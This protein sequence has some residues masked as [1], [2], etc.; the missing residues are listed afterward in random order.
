[1]TINISRYVDPGVY[2]QEVIAPGA[3]SVSSERIAAYVAIA[4]RTRRSRNEGVV[5]GKIYNETLTVA[6]S[7]PHTATLVNTADRNRNNATL[8]MNDNALGIGDWSILSAALVG[9]AVLILPVVIVGGGNDKFTVSL[10]GRAPL[11]IT[12]PAGA[13]PLGPAS[14]AGSI[15]NQIN[16]ALAASPNYGAS[17]AA[18]ASTSTTTLADDTLTLTS[19]DTTSASDVKVL[20]SL[21][22]DGAAA[23][24]GGFWSP[25]PTAGVQAQTRIQ[26][27]DEAFSSAATYKL[28]YLS[29]DLTLDVLANASTSTPL[30][31]IV[32]V[33]AYPGGTTYTKDADY[34]KS[35][36]P[37]NEIE[38]GPGF[39]TWANASITGILG[40]GVALPAVKTG[41]VGPYFLTPG[42]TFNLDVD[43]GGP[44]A[45]TF[46]ATAA[47]SVGVAPPFPIG[48][49]APGLSMDI[50]IDGGL[51]Q[52]VTTL[53]AETS[54]Y[55]VANLI[56]GSV[57]G[58]SAI[59]IGAGVSVDIRSDKRG[60]GSKVQIIAGPPG[61]DLAALI[62]QTPGIYSG[63]GNVQDIT[64]VSNIEVRNIINIAWPG[65]TVANLAGDFT[66]T[67]PTT[68]I[69]STLAFT[70]P[71]PAGTLAALGILAP[72]SVTGSAATGFAIG[73]ANDVLRVN[74][75]GRGFVNIPLTNG[76]AV[77][78]ATVAADINAYLNTSPLYGPAYAFTASA[79]SGAVILQPLNSFDNYPVEVGTAT[80][81]EFLNVAA[82]AFATIFGTIT[83]PYTVYGVGTR[84]SFGVT[85]FV[86]Y[87]YTRP[88]TDYET[89]WRVFDP[90]A[91]YEYTTQLTL[92]NYTTNKL[93]IAGEIAFENQANSIW[94]VQIN[95]STT[96]GTPTQTQIKHAIDVC[97]EKA[98]ITEVVVIDTALDT[99]VYTM[100]HVSDQSSLLEKH[101]RRGWF[102]MARGTD[103]GDP[104]TPDTFVY[105]SAR[106]LQPGTT[107]PGRG[108][109]LLVAPGDVARTLT[110]DTGQEVTVNLDGSYL[111][112]AVAA[113]FTALPSPSSTLMGKF[114]TGFN[115]EGFGTYLRGERYTLADKGV[116]VVTLDAG[117]LVL[118]DPLT[119]E[120]G[121]AKVVQF[122][123][124]SASAQKDAVTLTIDT[125]LSGNV[126][127][128]VPDDL[129]DF[130]TDVKKWIM[131]GIL[132]HINA[133]TI[134]PYRNSAGFPRDIDAT[135]DIQ[136]YQSS[137]DPRTFY[138]KYWFNL[139]YPAKRFFGE[140]S[141]DNPFFAPTA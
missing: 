55:D 101:Y 135:S 141:V 132:A 7:S 76:P 4:P 130:I 40:S 79:P 94:L 45:V 95:D 56:N 70:A 77:S 113:M 96:P 36:A 48:P 84:P 46:L 133:G 51:P 114:V 5:R 118:I 68:G 69:L 57:F 75:N 72:L 19:V 92:E 29:V 116:T 22:G 15:A 115:T 35:V 119:T 91:L 121:G 128:V 102:G 58:G 112:G 99:A 100:Q 110:L 14:L 106:T 111:A 89:A 21:G 97:K 137:T 80:R 6:P 16:A 47:V 140:Y 90:D 27:R 33:G 52:T 81:I 78:A 42:A 123:E 125:L 107:S 117:R 18:T 104:D 61:F 138:F 1:M 38:W 50:V 30:S 59:V 86:T 105:R 54:A 26:I 25:S 13:T 73:P 31:K 120:A 124:P 122:E 64:A 17:Y 12:F 24:S 127:G 82:S 44:A 98:G 11:T 10:D 139:K 65:S 74:I 62:G 93:C 126:V 49:L 83:L 63:G 88:A 39:G 134:G 109:L 3:V 136:V 8:Y 20:R 66:V 43:G 131:L 53:G 60:L 103:V 67:S 34:R 37:P 129:S 85:Y 9:S 28:D 87:D 41:G 23:I 71:S 2:I 108:R 32:N